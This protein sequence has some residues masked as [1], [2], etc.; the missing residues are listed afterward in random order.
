M[1]SLT[2][3]TEF[4][5]EIT[6]SQMGRLMR[7]LHVLLLPSDNEGYPCVVVEARACGV[8]VVATDVGGVPEALAG[9]GLLIKKQANFEKYFADAVIQ[10][11]KNPPPLEELTANI[12]TWE[13]VAQRELQ[14]YEQLLAK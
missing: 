14:I 11:L 10:V 13:E 12:L 9:G 1:L 2:N 6:P 7:S 4:Y 3:C 8:P 5:G